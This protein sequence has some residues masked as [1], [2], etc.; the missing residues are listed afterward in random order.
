M[1]IPSLRAWRTGGLGI[2]FLVIILQWLVVTQF[3]EDYFVAH[4]KFSGGA[5]TIGYFGTILLSMG[6]VIAVTYA[7]WTHD[8]LC[9]QRSRLRFLA[10]LIGLAGLAG[11]LVFQ[12]MVSLGYI[13]VVHR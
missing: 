3:V 11:L 12:G 2:A 5:L 6:S 13:L 1:K 8:Q 4:L 9:A 7:I 10:Q